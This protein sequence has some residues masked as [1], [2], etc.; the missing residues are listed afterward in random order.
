M[1]FLRV[2]DYSKVVVMKTNDVLINT[3]YLLTIVDQQ[4]AQKGDHAKEGGGGKI[5]GQAQ[6]LQ[7]R[8]KNQ[9]K[10]TCKGRHHFP[11]VLHR[12]GTQEDPTNNTIPPQTSPKSEK[13]ITERGHMQVSYR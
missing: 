7:K 1:F 12:K 2:V 6:R 4:L 3:C 9:L 13:Q 10:S 5:M 11:M 8:L